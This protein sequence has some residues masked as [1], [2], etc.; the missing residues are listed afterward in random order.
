MHISFKDLVEGRRIEI[1]TT[2]AIRFFRQ[3]HQERRPDEQAPS[4]YAPSVAFGEHSQH[5]QSVIMAHERYMQGKLNSGETITQEDIL[6]AKNLQ[7]LSIMASFDPDT[8]GYRDRIRMLEKGDMN[9][10]TARWKN[11]EIKAGQA[12]ILEG[13]SSEM[14]LQDRCSV[15]QHLS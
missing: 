15:S 3:E 5:L 6:A 11:M 14:S 8:Q 4:G 7:K 9:G 1:D 12:G 2:Q 13:Q 10:V